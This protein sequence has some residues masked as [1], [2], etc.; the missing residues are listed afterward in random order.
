MKKLFK[1][2]ALIALTSFATF[3]TETTESTASNFEIGMYS[4][5]NSS[6]V[7]LM[8]EKEKG[9]SLSISLKNKKGEVIFQEFVSKKSTSYNK[10]FKL[11]SLEDG[12]YIFE[13]DN[14]S[15][16]LTK[17]VSTATITNRKTEIL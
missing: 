4:I 16:K 7:R 2:F 11:A 14:G 3:A 9:V 6:K 13:I 8:L 5:T 17:T 12:T 1:T 10:Y 15:E